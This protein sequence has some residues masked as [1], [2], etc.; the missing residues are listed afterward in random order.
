[1]TPTD[2]GPLATTRGVTARPDGNMWF[3]QLNS[4]GDP[5]AD[6]IGKIT[7]SAVITDYQIP[8]ANSGAWGIAS[9]AT[10]TCTSRSSPQTTLHRS[11]RAA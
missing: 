10:A 6:D 2:A 8:T 7:S 3:T 9:G 11:P 5:S 1:M 4:N